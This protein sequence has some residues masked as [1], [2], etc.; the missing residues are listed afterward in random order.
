LFIVDSILRNIYNDV[1]NT[2]YIC[3]E[4]LLTCLIAKYTN[5]YKAVR[6]ILHPVLILE[7]ILIPIIIFTYLPRYTVKSAARIVKLHSQQNLGMN[8]QSEHYLIR[9]KLNSGNL[10]VKYDYI[11]LL[12]TD[13]GDYSFK[14]DP[15][16]GQFDKAN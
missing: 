12:T 10:L 2:N 4:F 7:I 9:K 6:K 1:I 8:I 14:F 11:I 15:L 16:T 3:W 5:K 13:K